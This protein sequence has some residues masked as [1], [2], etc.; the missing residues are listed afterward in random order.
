MKTVS[1]GDIEKLILA[2]KIKHKHIW[3]NLK[4]MSS[5]HFYFLIMQPH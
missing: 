5:L 2:L 3:L 1:Y 4:E